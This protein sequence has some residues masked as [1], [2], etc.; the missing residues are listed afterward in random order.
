LSGNSIIIIIIIIIISSIVGTFPTRPF[1]LVGDAGERDPEVCGEIC[2]RC[3]NE[4]RRVFSRD[5]TS[6]L[7]EQVLAHLLPHEVK[8]EKDWHCHQCT[9]SPRQ[10]V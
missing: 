5:V 3:P 9:G 1:L 8:K 4:A 2:R 6:D 7:S 10:G